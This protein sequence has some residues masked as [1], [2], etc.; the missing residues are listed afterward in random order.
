MDVEEGELAS[1]GAKWIVMGD[2]VIADPKYVEE[3]VA[4]RRKKSSLRP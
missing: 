1:A 2:K 3:Y 4:S